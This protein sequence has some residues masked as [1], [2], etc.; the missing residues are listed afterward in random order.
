MSFASEIAKHTEQYRRRLSFVAKTATLEVVNAARLP[1][2]SVAHPG[3]GAGGR[4][5]IDTS[6]LQKS[7]VASLSG[8]P[9]GPTTGNESKSG[10]DVTATIIRW[11]PGVTQFWTGWAAYYAREMEYRY[12]FLRGATERWDEFVSKAVAEAKRKNL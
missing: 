11:Q 10:D 4:M 7:M 12:G 6:N 8:V 9:T 2:P 3:G 1:G 5:P